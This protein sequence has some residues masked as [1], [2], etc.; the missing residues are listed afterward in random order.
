V[1]RLSLTLR[2]LV[3]RPLSPRQ[4]CF[5]VLAVCSSLLGLVAAINLIVDP[6]AQYASGILPPVVQTG[7][8]AKLSLLDGYLQPPQ[9]LVLGSSRVLKFEPKY[10]GSKTSRTYF[11][12]GVN[13]GR[14]EDFLALYRHFHHRFA[15]WPEQMIVGIDVVALSDL[16]SPDARL[17]AEP[18]LAERI[19][20]VIDWPMV[21]RPYGELCSWQQL[22]SSLQA[23]RQAMRHAGA[24][25]AD[26]PPIEYFC[27]DGLLVYR[28]RE[29]QLAQG[30]Y[31]FQSALEYNQREFTQLA[32]GFQSISLR[33]CYWLLVLAREAQQNGTKIVFFVT[34]MHP[35]LRDHLEP[36]TSLGAR[37]VETIAFL[38]RLAERCD[39]HFIDLSQIES[40]AGDPDAFVD[41]IHPLESN[42]RRMIDRML[43]ML[44]ESY[45]V[46]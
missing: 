20:E 8:E 9:G 1:R 36:R 3:C 40:F 44:G 42:T 17:V 14:P 37:E 34:P 5:T 29:S 18:R 45:A 22:R 32:E 28:Q 39:H 19:P 43:P 4:Y 26:E 11:N 10:V 15:K 24:N 30:N 13:N 31:D 16:P 23:I 41:G 7:R 38:Q 12:A 21:L 35:G 6:Y 2:W 25:L 33:R 27:D 46:Q